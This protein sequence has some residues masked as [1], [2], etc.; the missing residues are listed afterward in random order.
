MDLKRILSQWGIQRVSG[1]QRIG[2]VRSGAA[3]VAVVL[4]SALVLT[5]LLAVGQDSRAQEAVTVPTD[6]TPQQIEIGRA[7]WKNAGCAGCHGWA[8]HGAETEPV[9]PAPSLRVTQLDYASIHETIQCG[10]P[11]T[12]MPYHDRLAYTDRR[13]YGSTSADLGRDKPQPGTPLRPK[14]IDDLAVYVAGYLKGRGKVTK[15]ECEVDF[16]PGSGECKFYP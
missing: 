3:F 11:G 7:V 1:N 15:A 2:S 4:I 16:G 6:F 5:G 8:G 14:E 10:R 13:C 9:P 12:N